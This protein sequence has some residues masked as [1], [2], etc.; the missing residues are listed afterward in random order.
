MVEPLLARGRPIFVEKPLDVDLARARR[1]PGTARL[2][3]FVMHKWRYHPGVEALAG[4]AR[5]GELGAVRGLEL[6]RV[7]RGFPKR[8]KVD[9]VWNHAPHDV[10]IA[11]HVLGEAPEPVWAHPHPL[12]RPGGGVV[13]LFRTRAGVE[14]LY[15]TSVA[16]PSKRR[17]TILACENGW[18]QLPDALADHILVS[19]DGD[20]PEQRPIDTTMPLLTELRVFLAHLAGGPPPM[21]SLEE[22]LVMLEAVAGMRRLAGLPT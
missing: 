10:S 2:L 9:P 20:P 17:T 3:V 19:R 21:T 13:A 6:Q 5:S 18:A 4:I 1:L 8:R 15:A 7:D 16:S 11:F 22:E 12:D 14:I